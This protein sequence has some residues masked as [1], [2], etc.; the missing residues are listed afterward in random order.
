M[1]QGKLTILRHGSIG[2]DN[3][4]I[5][6]EDE[7]SGCRVFELE[8]SLE[9]FTRAI[10]NLSSQDCDFLLNIKDINKF[11]KQKE[12]KTIYMDRPD[13]FCSQEEIRKE[14]LKNLQELKNNGEIEQDWQ[15]WTDGTNQQQNNPQK[16]HYCICRY[17]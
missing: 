1:T 13:Y 17:V 8:I 10:T 5:R 2:E 9:N 4:V 3:I 11:D 6:L 14:V 15:I 16:Y 12:V 7:K